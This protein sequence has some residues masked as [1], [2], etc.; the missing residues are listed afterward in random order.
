MKPTLLP[1]FIVRYHNSNFAL[2]QDMNRYDKHVLDVIFEN[3]ENS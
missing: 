1:F 3:A 2:K